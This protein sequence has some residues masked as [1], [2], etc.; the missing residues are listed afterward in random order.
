M[1]PVHLRDLGFQKHHP[2]DREGLSR[3]RRPGRG[4]LGHIGGW[5]DIEVNHTHSGIHIPIEQKSHTRGLEGYGSSSSAPP[6]PQRPFSREHG[7]KRFNLASHWT[8]I[9]E[10]CQKIC[11]KEIDFRDLMVITKG[12]NAT[13]QFKLLEV[14]E[15]R[16]REI[17]ATIQAIEEQL[18]QKGNTQI[19]SGSQGEGQISSP[20]AAHHSGTNRSVAKSHHPSQ[21]QQASRRIQGYKGRKQD[22]LQPKEERVRPNEPEDVGF[23][24]RSTQEPEVVLH[25]ARFSIPINALWLQMSQYSE[26]TQKQFAELEASHERMK[27]LTGSMDKIVENLQQGHSK[28]SKSSE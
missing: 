1:S 10:I 27:K 11:L 26:K 16:I 2:E 23:G 19:A 14:R 24:E 7:G 21:S 17:Q 5:K 20:V 6:T 22:H 28:L 25:N 9:G 18:T 8:E 15:N 3:I 12:W 4:R 13:R